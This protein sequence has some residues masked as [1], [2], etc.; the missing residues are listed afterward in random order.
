MGV[1]HI[2]SGV[3][4][5]WCAMCGDRYELGCS[6]TWEVCWASVRRAEVFSRG[7]AKCVVSARFGNVWA[8]G[9]RDS[10]RAVADQRAAWAPLPVVAGVSRARLQAG[11]CIDI[12]SGKVGIG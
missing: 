6:Q 4:W 10:G 11:G 9:R 3:A 5:P 12:Q 7:D 8:G 2:T 1:V